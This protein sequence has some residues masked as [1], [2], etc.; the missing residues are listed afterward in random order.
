[1][2]HNRYRQAGGEDT[3]VAAETALLAERGHSVELFTVDNADLADPSGLRGRVRLARDTIWSDD[4]ARRVAAA[5]Q[6]ARADVVHIHN[7][8]PQLSPA[9]HGAVRATGAAVVQTLHNYRLVCPAATLLRDGHVCEDCRSLPITIPA[10]VHGCYRD[11]RAQSAAITAMLAVHRLRRTWV[12]DVDAFIALTTFGANILSSGGLPRRRIHVKPNFVDRPV[13]VSSGGRSGFLVAGRLSPEKGLATLLEAWR[14]ASLPASLRIVGDG[15]M[16]ADVEAAAR[17]DPSIT[18]VGA[19][20]REQVA[21]EMARASALVVPSIWY[22]G[23]PMSIIEAFAS[24]LPV[25]ASDLGAMRD[26]VDDGRVGRLV[27]PG[28]PPALAEALRSAHADPDGLATQGR[29]ARARYEAHYTADANYPRLVE[30]YA[31]AL[32]HRG[33]VGPVA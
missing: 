10:V 6:A 15:P 21:D 24:G 12:R 1:V 23:N 8:V 2:V 7:F 3:V 27:P 20:S 19:V 31:S 32:A 13:P 22:E 11:S 9:V 5:A 25:I 18:V 16:R 4:S 14:L 33:A 30:I 29:A 28:D 17:R 26:M